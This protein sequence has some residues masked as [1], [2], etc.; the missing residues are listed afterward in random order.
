MTKNAPVFCTELFSSLS[1]RT[2][3]NLEYLQLGMDEES[4]KELILTGEGYTLE[5]KEQFSSNLGKEI[6]AF[7]NSDGGKIFLGIDDNG[8]I[9]GIRKSNKLASEIQTLAR[10]MEPPI[11]VQFEMV[12]NVGVIY[13]PTGKD[14]P[15]SVGGKFY[16]RE[17]ANSQRL[18]RDE[19]FDF[20]QKHNKVSFEKKITED[21]D[22]EDDFDNK[23]FE[24]FLDKAKIPKDLPRKHILK[25]LNLLTENMP[26]NACALMFSKKIT[27]FHLNADISCVLY[28]GD[29]KISM[30]DKKEFDGDFIFNFESALS[31]IL[32]NIRNAA[33]IVGSRRIET[34]EIPEKAIREAILNAMIHRDYFNNSR[35]LINIFDSKVEIINAGMLLFPEKDLGTISFPR[36]PILAD[37]MLRAGFVER[38][39]SGI[40]RIRELT[41]NADIRISGEWFILTFKRKPL[42]SKTRGKQGINKGQ[43]RGKQGK[44]SKKLSL[45]ER[46]KWILEYLEDHL[47]IKSSLVSKELKV[48]PDIARKDLLYLSE[49][50]K[51][52]KKGSGSNVW[53]ELIK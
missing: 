23:A 32:R 43:T 3:I 14:K 37:C 27:K 13:V 44:N 5:F 22:I 51:I 18:N 10:N 40:K 2:F 48:S 12:G 39:G 26:N 53:Y 6:C 9:K 49:D 52:I 25:N 8:K 47:K 42:I 45:E 34:P 38:I 50:N 7:A 35:I 16:L 36:N 19:L 29:S 4:L 24:N 15:Y 41:P 28:N 31:F 33:E 1:L 17:G 30:L 21:F 20:V 11:S 46:R